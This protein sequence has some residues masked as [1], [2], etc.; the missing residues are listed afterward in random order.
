MRD[1]EAEACQGE[2]EQGSQ[3]DITVALSRSLSCFQ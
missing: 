2:E 3:A 1:I